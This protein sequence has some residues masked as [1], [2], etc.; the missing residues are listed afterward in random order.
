MNRAAECGHL[1]VVEYLK[2]K[3]PWITNGITIGNV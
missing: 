1:E 2:E 3:R